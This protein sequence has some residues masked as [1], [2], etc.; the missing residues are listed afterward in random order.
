MK[1]ALSKLFDAVNI[2]WFLFGI[3]AYTLILATII[4]G[5]IMP[6]LNQYNIRTSNQDGI[7]DMYINL[8]SLDIYAAIDSINSQIMDLEKIESNFKQRLIAANEFNS[9]IQAI[10]QSC[11]Q[12]KIKIRKLGP[13]DNPKTISNK[14]TKKFIK[15]DLSGTFSNF[16]NLLLNMENYSEWLLIEKLII[17]NDSDSELLNYNLVISVI[18]ENST[19]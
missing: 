15:A 17:N 11:N 7:N 19:L 4:Y 13:I 12:T 6:P 2:K 18:L 3:L 8:I 14:F 1:K 9:I 16:L 10:D 5:F